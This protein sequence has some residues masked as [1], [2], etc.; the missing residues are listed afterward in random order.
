MEGRRTMT[1]GTRSLLVAWGLLAGGT[2]EAAE[3][4]PGQGTAVKPV[5]CRAVDGAQGK[6]GPELA[7]AVERDALELATQGYELAALLPGD[8]PVA[9]YRHFGSPPKRGAK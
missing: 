4:H 5:I 3:T 7:Q 6:T 2:V 9:C 8:R 1:L